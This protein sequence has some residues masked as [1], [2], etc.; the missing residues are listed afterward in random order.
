M[1]VY[2]LMS[3]CGI[4]AMVYSSEEIARICIPAV[5]EKY[6]LNTGKEIKIKEI[7][8][9]KLDCN[10]AYAGKDEDHF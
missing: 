6:K 5:E 7:V 9:R 2:I 8:K 1:L 3:E 4:A 10:A